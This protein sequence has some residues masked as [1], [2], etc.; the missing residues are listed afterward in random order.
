MWLRSTAFSDNAEL[1]QRYTCEGEDLSPPLNWG[2]VPAQTRSL[3]LLC[4]DPDAPSGIWHHWAA[5]NIPADRSELKEGIKRQDAGFHQAVNDFG[6]HGYSGPCPPRGKPHHYHFQLSALSTSA[7]PAPK[8][9][10]CAQVM[11][12]ARPF[13]LESAELVGLYGRAASSRR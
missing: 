13:M 1:P 4:D 9:A 6:D 12:S 2:D 5:Y 3:V 11:K 7:L 10:T 8:S